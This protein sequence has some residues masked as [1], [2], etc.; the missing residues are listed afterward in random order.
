MVRLFEEPVAA[1][2]MLLYGAYL[3]MSRSSFRQE[4][5]AGV[6]KPD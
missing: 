5:N 3:Y 2:G 6:S 4:M 1:I